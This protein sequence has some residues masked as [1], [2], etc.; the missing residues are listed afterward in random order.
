[1]KHKSFGGR[2]RPSNFRRKR[3]NKPKN[4]V[5]AD[6]QFLV[7][8]QS[9][10]VVEAV[11]EYV[12]KHKFDD[13]KLSPKIKLNIAIK[14]YKNPTPIQDQTIPFA[15]EGKD[16]VGIAN[17]GTGKTAAFL[18]PLLNQ[19]LGDR[20]QKVLILAPT[21]ELAFQ[22]EDEFKSFA[23]NLSIRSVLCIGGM[24]M[25]T[26]I[27][28]LKKNF[29]FIIGTPGRVKDLIGRRL[30]KLEQYASVVLDEVDRMLDIGF[31]KDIREILSGL[32]ARRQSLFFSATVSAE[33]E[34]LI[35]QFLNNPIKISVA[36]RETAV[37][38]RQKLVKVSGKDDKINILKGFLGRAEFEKVL[39]FG[40]TKYGV[41]KLCRVLGK[42][43]FR[44]DSIHGNKSQRQRQRALDKFKKAHVRVLVATDVAA[45]G[46]DID[47]V[48]HVVNYDLPE[49]RDDYIHRIGRTGRGEKKGVALTFV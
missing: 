24:S 43:G 39:V 21:R 1:M 46:L 19:V 10:N 31:I 47:N 3:N 32:P 14:G 25:N 26:Q 37:N 16:V 5:G 9:H 34:D 48:S 28:Q 11:Q 7:D 41:D 18:L 49:S 42:N 36:S 12:C 22:I 13:F 30:I 2:R 35:N 17:T 38:V 20:N 4:N 40:R 23:Q 33:I 27:Y 29:N 15:L 44:V 6:I 8:S 45:R